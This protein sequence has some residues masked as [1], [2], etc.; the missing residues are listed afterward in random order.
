MNDVDQ[1]IKK[2]QRLSV[3]LSNY[4]KVFDQLFI[5]I[6]NVG[7]ESG[8][9]EEN[10]EYLANDLEKKADLRKTTVNALIYPGVVVSLLIVVGLI[11]AYFV[12][13]QMKKLFVGL[14]VDLPLPSRIL[15]AV[16]E[17]F[18]SY[19]NWIILAMILLPFAIKLAFKITVLKNF[20]HRVVI[21]L[22]TVRFYNL[23]LV[24]RTLHILLK[25]GLTINRSLEI[26][27]NVVKN[28]VYKKGLLRMIKDV[29]KGERM[30]AS[31]Q[32]I[33]QSKKHS[34][35]PLLMIKMINVGESSGNLKESLD[36]LGSYYEKEVN[37]ITKNLTVIIEPLLLVI[38][39][40]AVLFLALAVIMPIS[41]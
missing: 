15:L 25:S 14:R 33:K 40:I 16:S 12:L 36:Y 29:E 13:P 34:I 24:N 3:A 6:I 41:E 19:G 28:N 9:L 11:A 21:N 1:R 8:T 10:L 20:W 23:T 2:G 30:S 7:E 4:P 26:T 27:S 18:E 35:F 39:A 22:P 32:K 38:V 5:S 31:M 17:I 37:D